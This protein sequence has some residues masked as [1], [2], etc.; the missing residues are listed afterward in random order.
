MAAAVTISSI[1]VK[2]LIDAV[3]TQIYL[4]LETGDSYS[5]RLTNV[6]DNMNVLLEDVKKTNKQGTATQLTKVYVRGSNVV[7]F[8]LPDALATSPA[9]QAA[10]ALTTAKTDARGAGAGFGGGRLG[11]KKSK[12][13]APR[14]GKRDREAE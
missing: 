2:I 9:V 3:G 4:E 8:Q 13:G 11:D 14:G 7:F 1:P 12:G 6:E 10:L 5:G